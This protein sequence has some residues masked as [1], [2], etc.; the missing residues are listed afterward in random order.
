MAARPNTT[1]HRAPSRAATAASATASAPATITV[2]PLTP[3]RWPDLEAVFEARGCSMAR[4]CWC[5]YYRES[6]KTEVPPGETAA[7][8]RKARLKALAAGDPPPGVLAYRGRTPVGWLSFGPREGFARLARSPVM[9]P[10]DA[11][12]VWSVVCF[13]VPPAHRHQGVATAL[14]QG[15]IAYAAKKG[16]RLLEAYPVDKRERGADDWL[17]FGARSMYDKAGFTEVAR[18]RPE[19]P[20]VRLAIAQPRTA[21][22]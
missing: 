2:R 6:G 7:S 9:K 18:R 10:V 19:R 12:P 1:T 13:V 22:P 11:Q 16:A 17:W 15:A 14:L 21:K 8:A 4:G 5:M 3:A 20:V